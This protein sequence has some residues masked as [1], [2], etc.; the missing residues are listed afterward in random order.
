MSMKKT[1]L[2]AHDQE[3]NEKNDIFSEPSM[4]EARTN[5]R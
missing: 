5:Q 4:P 3:L 1:Q 2:G